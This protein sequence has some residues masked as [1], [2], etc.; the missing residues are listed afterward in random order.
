[1][2]KLL[3]ALIGLMVVSVLSAQK[4]NWYYTHQTS[5]PEKIRFQPAARLVY[6]LK[7]TLDVER[8]NHPVIIPR[9]EFPM[10]DIHE[11][12][13]TIV[14]PSLPSYEGPDAA[15]LTIY[16]G[17]QL[18]AEVHGHA[19]FHQLDDLDK[20]GIWDE[21][22]FQT[23]LKPN[24]EKLIYIY[25][26]ENIQGWNKHSTHANVGSYCRHQMPF[27]ETENVGW[28]IWFANCCD[29]FAKR[30][31]E[32]MSNH[33]YMKNL[34]GYGVSEINQDWGSDIQSVAGSMG[35]GAI[36]LF[37]H[38]DKPDSIS[39]P[40]FTPTREKLVPKSLWNAGQI[41]DTR[42][43]YEVVV[44]GPV[45]SMIKIKTM[46]WNSGSGYYNLEQY[47][48]VYAHQSYS[49]CQVVYK[50]FQPKKAG[51]KMGCGIRK[52]PGEEN[53]YQKG[54]VLI[55]SG[56]EQIKDPEDIDERDAWLMPFIG[57][58]IVVK[59]RYLPEY[60]FTECAKG[61]HTFKVVPD[62]KNSFEYMIFAA[63]SE[64]AVY[65]NQEDFEAYVQKTSVEFNHP[66][67]IGFVN[68]EQKS[69]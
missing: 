29:V 54:G 22:F 5:E 55:S 10:P 12:W 34:D 24:E 59:D 50:D 58:A 18:L 64:G 25:L 26:G 62:S 14:D 35:G 33:L 28:K 6:T 13:I 9:E 61:S 27:W 32:L 15:V 11:M 41:S 68:I 51:V 69:K 52:K 8:K 57:K 46:N 53:L 47:Y 21:L 19:V 63:W 56:P 45:R 39:L 17:H 37:E 60:Q 4:G 23:D 44:N 38:P 36:C 1:M 2:R 49:T 31:P 65:N 3:Y 66:I 20:D 30:K 48:T 43:A 7:N 67:E 40:R 42:Y 16:G